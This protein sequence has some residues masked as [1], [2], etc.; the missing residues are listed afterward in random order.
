MQTTNTET[1]KKR[2]KVRTH[3]KTETITRR[4]KEQVST[5]LTIP[6]EYIGQNGSTYNANVPISVT[7]CPKA[8]V[9]KKVKKGKTHKKGKRKK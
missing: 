1:V 8:K 5:A 3:G 2:V 9:A 7:G 6:S 4:L